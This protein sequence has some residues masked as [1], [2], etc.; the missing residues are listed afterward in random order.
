[1]VETAIKVVAVII[2]GRIIGYALCTILSRL[3]VFR[4]F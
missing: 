2:L 3:G 1:M 4:R